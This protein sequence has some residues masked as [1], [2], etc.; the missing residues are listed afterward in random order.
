MKILGKRPIGR[1]RAV[2]TRKSYASR[3]HNSRPGAF[4]CGGGGVSICAKLVVRNFHK[5]YFGQ[6]LENKSISQN[7]KRFCQCIQVKSFLSSITNLFFL[8]DTE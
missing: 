7:Q 4:Y 6:I 5:D 3:D 8:E 1:G 2:F